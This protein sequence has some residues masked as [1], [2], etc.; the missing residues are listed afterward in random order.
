M[1]PQCGGDRQEDLAGEGRRCSRSEDQAA[2][3]QQ[4][5]LPED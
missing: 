3:V 5:L 2:R 1:P 4:A